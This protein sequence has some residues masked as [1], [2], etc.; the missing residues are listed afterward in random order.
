M[1][2]AAL[3]SALGLACAATLAAAAPPAGE[4]HDPM[5]RL[6]QAD[7]NGD[8]M[9]SRDEAKALP[10]IAK[11]FD[12]ID[13]NHDNQ[14]TADELRAFHAQMSGGRH[15]KAAERFKKLDT[16]GD[17]RI[18]RAEA[19]ASPRLSKGFDAIDANKDGYI[20]PD[21]LKAAR[22]QRAAK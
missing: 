11:H 16:D 12:E 4:G 7:T 1:R 6:K 10:M 18:S 15:A 20:T 3:L 5:M 17:G 22:E 13:T 14:I 9:I 2:Y 21:E 8:G 19:Q